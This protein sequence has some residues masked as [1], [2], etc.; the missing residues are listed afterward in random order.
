ME[1]WT[2]G[3]LKC[4][5]PA[6]QAHWKGRW[7]GEAPA[8]WRWHQWVL[9]M[10]LRERMPPPGAFVLL[11]FGVDEGV[12][13]NLGREGAQHTPLQLRGLAGSLPVHDPKAVLVDAGDLHCPDGQLEDSQ[14]ALAEVIERLLAQ[15]CQP[16]VIGG[17]HEVTYGHQKGIRQF[18]SKQHP[19]PRLGMINLDAHFDNRAVGPAGASSG[20]GFWQAEE[21]CRTQ[22]WPFAYM[23]LGIQEMSNTAALWARAQAGHTQILTTQD[24]HKQPA[25]AIIEQI[26]AFA[27]TCDGLYV[28]L[29]ID[30]F[31]M[32]VAPGVSAPN[33]L[34]LFP[35]GK[36]LQVWHFLLKHP[37]T[38][39]VDIA[40]I[41][42]QFDPTQQTLRLGV[43]CMHDWLYQRSRKSGGK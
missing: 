32:S 26:E 43:A 24:W 23:A 5:L 31:H 17:G 12:R 1:S 7:D 40:E 30:V 33:G 9:C 34:G 11:G 4:Y 35:D 42:P 2:A 13:R 16:L 37:K 18:L 20:T 25:E 19:K 22:N 14:E 10:D 15:G 28:S 21:D 36:W 8:H 41:N 3:F 38:L 6:Q 27:T 39:S 29:D